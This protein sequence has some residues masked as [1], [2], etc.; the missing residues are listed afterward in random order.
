[1]LFFF[2]NFF[3]YRILFSFHGASGWIG[4]M[5][6]IFWQRLGRMIP[7]VIWL[8]HF[9]ILFLSSETWTELLKDDLA[10]WTSVHQT[11]LLLLPTL[12]RSDAI[13]RQHIASSEALPLVN[14][15][16]KDSNG[17]ISGAWLLPAASSYT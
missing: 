4:D 9:R 11:P 17:V 3:E 13:C 8:Y 5:R 14:L 12:A 6:K 7:R 15:P 16:D 1:M 2:L 10:I